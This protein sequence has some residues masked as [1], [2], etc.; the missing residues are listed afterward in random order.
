MAWN[1]RRLAVHKMTCRRFGRRLRCRRRCGRSR[2]ASPASAWQ[3]DRGPLRHDTVLRKIAKE[4]GGAA[5]KFEGS[6]QG[7]RAKP[8]PSSA[9]SLS[10]QP[11]KRAWGMCPQIWGH[12]GTACSERRSPLHHDSFMRKI[13]EEFREDAHNFVGVYLGANGESRPCYN[14]PRSVK[15][16]ALCSRASGGRWQ[17]CR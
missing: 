11:P 7:G 6:Y 17:A 16:S 4:L 3:E 2:R 13:R 8:L 1:C 9:R 12:I 10:A 15:R 14:L 5:L